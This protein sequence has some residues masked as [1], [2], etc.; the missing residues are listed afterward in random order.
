MQVESSSLSAI[1]SC[2]DEVTR[3]FLRL[4]ESAHEIDQAASLMSSVLLGGHKIM[5]CGNGGSA[6]DAQHL[7]A[8]LMGRYLRDRIPLAAVALTVDSSALTAIANDY[9]YDLVFARQL[10][11]LG[12]PGDLLYAISTSGNSRNIIEAVLAAKELGILTLGLTGENGGELKKLCESCICVPAT[13]TNRI[14]ELHIVV[15]H[16]LCGIVEDSVC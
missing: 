9:S 4:K 11:G 1:E 10:R 15:G 5:F 6:A 14:Q 8:E 2:I 7:S 3:G 16:L 12:K 13:A